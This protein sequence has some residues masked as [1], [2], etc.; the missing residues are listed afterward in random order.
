MNKICLIIIISF[1]YIQVSE[2]NDRKLNLG[3]AFNIGKRN[4][5]LGA[6]AYGRLSNFELNAGY[7]GTFYN[8][9]KLSVGAK[10]YIHQNQKLNPFIITNCSKVSNNIVKDD[11]TP[12]KEGYYVSANKYFT[13][14]AGFFIKFKDFGE[15]QFSFGYTKTIDNYS[16]TPF[17]TNTENKLYTMIRNASK[18]GIMLNYSIYFRMY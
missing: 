12:P 11:A 4:Y 3:V 7:G 16:I 2:A 13:V 8:G 10:Y 14:G 1:L 9:D 6:L 5:G 18:S 17:T 15:H